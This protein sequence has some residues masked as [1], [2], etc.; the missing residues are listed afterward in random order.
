MTHY[1]P[2]SR[3]DRA[4]RSVVTENPDDVA[5]NKPLTLVYTPSLSVQTVYPPGY[6]LSRCRGCQY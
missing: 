4:A 1:R 2:K 6:E 3:R 5:R